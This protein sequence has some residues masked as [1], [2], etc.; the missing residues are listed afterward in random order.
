MSTDFFRELPALDEHLQALAES[1]RGRMARVVSADGYMVTVEVPRKGGWDGPVGPYP[2]TVAGLES[3]ETGVLVPIRGNGAMFVAVG[4]PRQ[5]FDTRLFSTGQDA[6]NAALAAGGGTVFVGDAIPDTT[7]TLY[8]GVYLTGRGIGATVLDVTTITG[9]G[10]LATLPAL[11]ANV[12]QHARAV[13]F[14]SAPNLIPGDVFILYNSADSSFNTARTYYRAGEFCRVASISGSTVTLTTPTYAAYSSG[15]T[16]TAH[17]L[18]PI[19]TGVSGMTI[20]GTTGQPVIRIDLGTDLCFHDLAMSGSDTSHLT[21][22]RCYNVGISRVSAFDASPV[23]TPDATNYGIVLANSQRIRISDVDLETRRHGLTTG[24]DNS[25]GAVPCRDIRISKSYIGGFSDDSGVCGLNLHGNAE[26]I[27]IEH[28]TLP[29]GYNP[30]G[31]G[32]TVRNCEIGQAPW[33]GAIYGAELLGT[34]HAFE[35]NTLRITRNWPSSLGAVNLSFGATATRGNGLLKFADNT[36]DAGTY[37]GDGTAHYLVRVIIGSD[38]VPATNRLMLD[39]NLF[40][41]LQVV[42]AE[43]IG[44]RI[45]STVTSAGFGEIVSRNNTGNLPVRTLDPTPFMLFE[46]SGVG[47]PAFAASPGSRYQRTDGGA[48]TSLYIKE[49]T[50]SSGTWRAV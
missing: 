20:R 3:G 39:G 13:S 23:S 17:K 19:H 41:T 2:A 34:N 27:H 26:D 38:N 29:A 28:C 14:A 36:M 15:S 49:T 33:G 10:S 18:V 37:G 42:G 6:I 12:A 47:A 43:H 8:D 44:V 35:H 4:N 31:D 40:S 11:A 50:G 9:T 24:G 46:G 16:V 22:S 45:Q 5:I 21:L 25:T 7:L 1:S 48:S 30:G 32:V